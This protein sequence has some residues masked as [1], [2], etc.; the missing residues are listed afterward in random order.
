MNTLTMKPVQI[1]LRP[2]QIETARSAAS[3]R[4]VSFAE[5]VRQALDNFLTEMPAE[6]DS[7]WNII[8]S[9]DSGLGDLAEKHDEYLARTIAQESR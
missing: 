4:G 2:A 5:L 7:L 1:H 6:E 3:R 8:G 9:F